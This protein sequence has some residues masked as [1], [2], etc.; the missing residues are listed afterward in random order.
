[1]NKRRVIA[2]ILVVGL[3]AGW[4]TGTIGQFLNDSPTATVSSNSPSYEQP[5]QNVTIIAQSSNDPNNDQLRY[6][7][8]TDNDGTYEIQYTES[9]VVSHQFDSAGEY[10]VNTKVY[11]EHN[12]TDTESTIIKVNEPLTISSLNV[13]GVTPEKPLTADRINTLRINVTTSKPVETLQVE[14]RKD[15][16]VQQKSKQD[17]TKSPNTS[18]Y[19]TY[20]NVSVDLVSNVTVVVQK[21]TDDVGTNA[22]NAGLTK[23]V[24]SDKKRPFV[25]SF[26]PTQAPNVMSLSIVDTGSGVNKSAIEVTDFTISTGE[27]SNRTSKNVSSL[28]I[29]DKKAKTILELQTETNIDSSSI[30]V[31]LSEGAEIT[32]YAG[33]RVLTQD[34]SNRLTQV[35]EIDSTPPMLLDAKS[36]NQTHFQVTVTDNGGSGIDTKSIS[37]DTVTMTNGNVQSVSRVGHPDNQTVQFEI[38]AQSPIKNNQVTVAFRQLSDKNGNT[39]RAEEVAELSD[40]SAPQISSVGVTSG[41]T[42]D[43]VVVDEIS[44]IQTDSITGSDFKLDNADVSFITTE[45]IDGGVRVEVTVNNINDESAQLSLVGSIADTSGNSLG[46]YQTIVSGL[47][48][49]N[50]DNSDD[51]GGD[52]GGDTGGD[53][54][55]DSGGY[56]GGY[57]GGY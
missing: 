22:R 5:P 26:Q 55:D 29:T 38:V 11:D 9:S 27:D 24:Q 20:T 52:S 46:S 53:T 51:T 37:S 41:N 28:R 25:S 39:H 2:L 43:V 54:G 4:A 57:G 32:D 49:T 56:G 47:E 10:R 36:I 45:Q 19:T 33:N 16:L 42:L 30:S 12:E 34:A 50:T 8:D 44:S 17:F 48:P 13:S 31:G 18:T 1:M 23:T 6:S 7:Y 35:S 21:A 14:I 40:D 3:L 15:R